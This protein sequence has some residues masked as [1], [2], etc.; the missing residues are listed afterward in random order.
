MR[1]FSST[2][3]RVKICRPSGTCTT[4]SRTMSAG[5]RPSSR[6]PSNVIEPASMAPP[7]PAQVA[8][9]RPQQ[10]RL[11]RTVAAED[12]DHAALGHVDRDATQRTDR[13]AVARP[14]GPDRQHAGHDAGV[15]AVTVAA[16]G[17]LPPGGLRTE[18]VDGRWSRRA[19]WRTMH[20][21]GHTGRGVACGRWPDALRLGRPRTR[22]WS[23][24]RGTPRSS[25]CSTG[26]PR[27]GPSS[28]GSPATSASTSPGSA[29]WTR[30]ATSCW[31]TRCAR[32]PTPSTGSSCR[33]GSGSAGS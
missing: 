28:T 2:V 25:A 4:P 22:C 3:S 29:R 15:T 31:A 16:G 17:D 11:P 18:T 20:G 33:P 32:G 12:R 23:W 5:G 13:A 6:R 9:H 30:A 19:R 24:T 26:A 21:M 10:R 27:S 14:R 1:R 8:G 7:T